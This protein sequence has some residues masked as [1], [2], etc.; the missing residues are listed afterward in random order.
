MYITGKSK[1]CNNNSPKAGRAKPL[2]NV[3]LLHYCE[4]VE[5]TGSRL[6]QVRTLPMNPKTITKIQNKALD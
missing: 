2:Y 3:K 5:H 6:W 1:M 4:G